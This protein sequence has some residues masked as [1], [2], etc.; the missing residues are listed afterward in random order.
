MATAADRFNINSQLEHLQSRYVG[1]G[2]AAG[3]LHSSTFQNNL[4]NFCG[5]VGDRGTLGVAQRWGTPWLERRR[6]RGPRCGCGSGGGGG[7]RWKRCHGLVAYGDGG[8]GAGK[9]TF[10]GPPEDPPS[11]GYAA[12]YDPGFLA[13]NHATSPGP[14]AAMQLPTASPLGCLRRAEK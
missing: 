8:G 4:R 14:R 12:G 2:H 13:G 5:F 1:T 7:G 9:P 3:G 10:N 11:P 6:R